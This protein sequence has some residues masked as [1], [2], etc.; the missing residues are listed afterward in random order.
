MVKKGNT[1]ALCNEKTAGQIRNQRLVELI[2]LLQ[3][4][5]T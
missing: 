1:L 3:L 2:L 5:D 4:C